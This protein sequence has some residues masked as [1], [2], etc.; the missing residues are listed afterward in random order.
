M[1]N[2][3]RP[4][5][6]WLANA[7]HHY[8]IITTYGHIDMANIASGNALNLNQCLTN[9][10]CDLLILCWG[11][12]CRNWSR[13]HSLHIWKQFYICQSR[14]RHNMFERRCNNSRADPS[15]NKNGETQCHPSQSVTSLPDYPTCPLE[16]GICFRNMICN[17][18]TADKQLRVPIMTRFPDSLY[19]SLRPIELPRKKIIIQW[20]YQIM[21]ASQGISEYSME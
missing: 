9:Y 20:R 5:V 4:L 6:K 3:L 2:D 17:S 11:W 7:L 8:R 15:Q 16:S 19:A 10:E 18:P 14:W 12:F 21:F 1:N 13:C